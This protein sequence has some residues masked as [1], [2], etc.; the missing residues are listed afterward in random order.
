[1]RT[2]GSLQ[3]A[4]ES[5]EESWGGVA[6]CQERGRVRGEEKGIEGGKEKDG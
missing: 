4:V 3:G 6:L 2:G 1:M 5:C